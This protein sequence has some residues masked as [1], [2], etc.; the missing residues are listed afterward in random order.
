MNHLF[1]LPVTSESELHFTTFIL[2]T[3]IVVFCII[4]IVYLFK[5]S[6]Q[7]IRSDSKH[8]EEIYQ[9]LVQDWKR[10]NYAQI[11]EII[12]KQKF[13][14]DEIDELEFQLEQETGE[15]KIR[16]L[17]SKIRSQKRSLRKVEENLE[18]KQIEITELAEAYA[19][20]YVETYVKTPEN[21]NQSFLL[22]FAALIIVVSALLV[23]AILQIVEGQQAVTILAAVVGYVL[24]KSNT[25][26]TK[27]SKD[28]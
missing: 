7:T 23:L 22:E 13:I 8:S 25:Q 19:R 5:Y 1:S 28:T 17:G 20:E 21:V 26:G 24:G 4:G 9:L 6:F 15:D 27:I 14:L 18:K 11:E 2:V 16:A 12:V 3:L 10:K